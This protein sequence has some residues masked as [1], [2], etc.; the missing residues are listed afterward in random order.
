MKIIMVDSLVGNDYSTCLC[1]SL[2]DLGV[3]VNLV[4]PANRTF[5]GN[6]KFKI[7]YLSPSKVK[8]K[9]KFIKF[10]ELAQY[11][12]RLYKFIKL[13]NPDIVHYQFFRRNG[14]VLLYRLLKL[15]K[16]NLVQTAHNV[17]PHE[18][19]KIDHLIKSI[20][21]KNA[22]SIIV[23]SNFIKNKLLQAFPID[24]DKVQIVPHGNF[25]IYL[26]EVEF[27]IVELRKT[28]E[29]KREDNVILFFG[30][31]REYKGLD[32]LLDAFELS[33][34]KDPGLKLLIAGSVQKKL[35]QFYLDK[36]DQSEFKDRIIFHSGYIPKEKVAIY[37]SSADVVILPYKEIDHSGIIHL[38]YSF[39]KP[40]I[41]TNV[42]DFSEVIQ[43][44]KS[45]LLLNGKNAKELAEKIIKAFDNKQNLVQM[46]KNAR[47]LSETKYSWNFV[48]KETLKVYNE[49]A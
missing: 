16:I 8:D 31:I 23:H 6:E 32:I 24:N 47:R 3:E 20:V 28:L 9:N 4:V 48:A 25:D 21:Y 37:F 2:Y 29:I 22:K 35:E 12:I 13:N 18:N 19:S 41:A 45:G 33:A 43:N 7:N 39:G 15:K 49:I 36:I 27:D 10:I 34:S 44:N 30:F 11:Y 14:E 5:D 38:A 46:G 40:V 26:P 1:N 42:G 17:L